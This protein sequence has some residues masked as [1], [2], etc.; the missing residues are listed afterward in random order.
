MGVTVHYC[1]LFWP[2]HHILLGMEV[3][4]GHWEV[5]TCIVFVSQ[6]YGPEEEPS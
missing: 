4:P 1:S 5:F 3:R 2:G 6:D